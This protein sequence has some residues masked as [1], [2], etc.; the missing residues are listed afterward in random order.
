VLAEVV[1]G[2][3]HLSPVD[4]LEREVMDV[5]VALLGEGEDVVVAVH[6]QPAALLRDPVGDLEAQH[7]LVPLDHRLDVGGQVVD[8]PELSRVEGGQGVGRA[9]DRRPAV[10]GRA[11]LE[12]DH[13]PPL[14][15]DDPQAPSATRN[16]DLIRVGAALGEELGGGGE[17]E[18]SP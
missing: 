8:V 7:A 4:K 3:P 9:G 5:R 15:V 18:P 13:R 16:L 2:H 6:V 17:V 11:A 14:R 10:I 1:E 12:R